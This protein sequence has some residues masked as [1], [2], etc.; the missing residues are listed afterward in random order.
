MACQQHHKKLRKDGE[1]ALNTPDH[2]AFLHAMATFISRLDT[3]MNV[4]TNGD[5]DF[6]TSDDCVQYPPEK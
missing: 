5:I 4:K 6:T 1:G 2:H 3:H